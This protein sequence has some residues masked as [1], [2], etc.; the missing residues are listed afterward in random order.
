[1]KS[2][3]RGG[4]LILLA[5]ALSGCGNAFHNGTEMT[6]S[7]I[8]VTGLPSSIYGGTE[9]ILSY[10]TGGGWI[11]DKPALFD[12]GTY[13]GTV[14]ANGDW[15]VTFSPPLTITTST[16]TFLLID[17]GKNWGTYKI[18]KKH[19]GKSGGDVILD[20]PWAPASITGVVDGENVNWTI[21]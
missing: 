19:S 4:F 10:D 1:M 18:D 11:H 16:V 21:E 14:D 5:V 8:S 7:G 9:M 20:N 3:L 12:S 13:S 6:L 15:S 17:A 2:I